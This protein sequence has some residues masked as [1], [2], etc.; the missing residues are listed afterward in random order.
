M[1]RN[2]WIV[3]SSMMFLSVVASLSFNT[4]IIDTVFTF[5]TIYLFIKKTVKNC[6]NNECI[7]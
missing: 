5:G 4:F 1:K 7:K 2:D 3:I 6:V